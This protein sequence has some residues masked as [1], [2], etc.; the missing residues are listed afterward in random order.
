MYEAQITPLNFQ[1][2]PLVPTWKEIT[3]TLI[4]ARALAPRDISGKSDPYTL[5]TCGSS[6]KSATKL[7]FTR[8]ETK[9]TARSTTQFST[10]D[11]NWNEAFSMDYGDDR[12][13]IE[14]DLFDYDRIGK[15]MLC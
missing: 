15:V 2:T 6:G 8:T 1:V 9:Y 13:K 11:P 7:M 5:I 4:S 3:I 14:F 12:T 10:L